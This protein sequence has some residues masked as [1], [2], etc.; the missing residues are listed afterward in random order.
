LIS[1]LVKVDYAFALRCPHWPEEAAE[2][3]T[4]ER[5]GL[6]KTTVENIASRGCYLVYKPCG[7][8]NFKTIYSSLFLV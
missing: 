1:L 5:A 3:I 2:W 8:H 6:D 7:N 4:R